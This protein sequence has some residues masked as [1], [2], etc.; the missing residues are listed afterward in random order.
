MNEQKKKMSSAAAAVEAVDVTPRDT[1]KGKSPPS[2]S[3]DSKTKNGQ[4]HQQPP[5]LEESTVNFNVN[6][7]DSAVDDGDLLDDP[8]A[9]GTTVSQQ[10][11]TTGKDP[12]T[13]FYD[14]G[15]CNCSDHPYFICCRLSGESKCCCRFSRVPDAMEVAFDPNGVISSGDKETKRRQN[16]LRPTM[17][18]CG[19]K[20]GLAIVSANNKTRNRMLFVLVVWMILTITFLVGWIRSSVDATSLRHQLAM[21]LAP[22]LEPR[23]GH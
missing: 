12:D 3:S 1:K 15:C 13:Y 14:C 7:V 4:Q 21:V 8:P 11:Q 19:R 16:E 22:P 2:Q 6:D 17:I 20:N 18:C 9:L 10:Q 5:Q 23:I